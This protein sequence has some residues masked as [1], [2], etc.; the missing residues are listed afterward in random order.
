M[1][2]SISPSI[3]VPSQTLFLI[4]KRDECARA[5][6]QAAKSSI[7]VVQWRFR[8]FRFAANVVSWI[9]PEVR[10]FAEASLANQVLFPTSV[11]VAYN[12][13]KC[14]FRSVTVYSVYTC[15]DSLVGM[16]DTICRR[17]PWSVEVLPCQSNEIVCEWVTERAVLRAL[18]IAP[19]Q[20]H[21]NRWAFM[22]TFELL[23]EEMDR[24]P[25][26]SIFFWFFSLRWV[27]KS[28]ST[29]MIWRTRKGSLSDLNRL[30]ILSYSKLV[31]NKGYSIKDLVALKMRSSRSTTST[32]GGAVTEASPLSIARPVQESVQPLVVV[33]DTI[34][35]STLPTIAGVGNSLAKTHG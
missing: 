26:L 4:Y 17:D 13:I 31:T 34:E 33:V 27:K 21:P 29:G 20:L 6:W 3:P 23:S 15:L 24:E 14:G 16:T 25:S 11:F 12:Q 35:D 2:I 19:T 30:P 22:W 7:V 18:N 1:V 32:V 5:K 10:C 8:V 28:R 9:N